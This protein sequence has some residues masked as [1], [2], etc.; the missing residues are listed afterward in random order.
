MD[1]NSRRPERAWHSLS[2]Y[3]LRLTE[4]VRLLLFKRTKLNR[5]P[6]II[7]ESVVTITAIW[8]A[9]DI[10][11]NPKMIAALIRM[12]V[13]IVKDRT[14]QGDNVSRL[15]FISG[16]MFCIS[17]FLLSSIRFHVAVSYG[18]KDIMATVP[19]SLTNSA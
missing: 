14:V 11:T 4:V 6:R 12:A 16:C 19:S 3:W 13:N 18:Q 9:L 10:R 15:N 5:T 7:R 2:I 17:F 1:H 8:R